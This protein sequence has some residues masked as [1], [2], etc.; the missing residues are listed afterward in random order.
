[1]EGVRGDRL[2]GD[3]PVALAAAGQP[4]DL[5]FDAAAQRMPIERKH[6]PPGDFVE[7]R[8]G[9]G[10]KI[11]IEIHSFYLFD[12]PPAGRGGAASSGAIVAADMV[13]GALRAGPGA[14]TGAEYEAMTGPAPATTMAAAGSSVRAPLAAATLVSAVTLS[15][16]TF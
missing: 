2:Q 1:P 15:V 6:H 7:G 9:F 10:S 5:E 16:A 3:G 11:L 12:L 4:D 13:N 14:D 8:R